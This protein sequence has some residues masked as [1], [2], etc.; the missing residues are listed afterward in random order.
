MDLQEPGS[1]PDGSPD[2]YTYLRARVDFPNQQEDKVVFVQ[3][4]PGQFPISP[5]E[6]NGV[7]PGGWT[8]T[9]CVFAKG[10]L[11]GVGSIPISPMECSGAPPGEGE[12]MALTAVRWGHCWAR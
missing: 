3:L 11:P 12:N 5:I 2:S 4:P 9:A 8:C 7:S 6:C 10:S 1:C